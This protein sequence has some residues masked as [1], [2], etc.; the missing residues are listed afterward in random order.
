MG[1]SGWF[2][3]GE[4][5]HE[6]VLFERQP[7]HSSKESDPDLEDGEK[8]K[9]GVRSGLLKVAA[10]VG[11]QTAPSLS[12]EVPADAGTRRHVVEKVECVAR[13]GDGTIGAWN[14][15]PTSPEPVA[16]GAHSQRERQVFG[17]GPVVLHVE[18]EVARLSLEDRLPMVIR[19]AISQ[20]AD[21]R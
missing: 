19:N 13:R 11:E 8:L 5:R 17:W 6:E 14:R 15:C 20:L 7:V 18:G 21:S 1:S 4:S 16:L 10:R 2:Q 3:K 9:R 12:G